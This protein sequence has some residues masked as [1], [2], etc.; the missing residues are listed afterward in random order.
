[1]RYA[2]FGPRLS[3]ILIDTLVLAP[4][5][6]VAYWGW[7]TSRTTALLLEVPL[8]FV[9]AFYNIY[10]IGRWGQTVGKM[11]VKI[12]VVAL[13]GSE[14]GYVRAFY[15]HCVDLAFS[16]VAIA[17]S[18]AALLSIPSAQY[19]GA[20]F[21]EKMNLLNE[22][23]PP[24]QDVVDWLSIG[25]VLSE[26]VVLLT[27]EKRRALHDYIAGTVVVHTKDEGQVAV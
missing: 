25:W 23:T 22:R 26:L 14:A 3:A 15:R 16:I 20:S 6:A 17:L 24:W 7:S 18:M 27:N 21:Q 4:L 2:G 5:L 12:K 19:D 8:G 1:M 13:D 9:F 10:F 11:A